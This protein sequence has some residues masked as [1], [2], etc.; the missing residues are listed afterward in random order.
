M[1]NPITLQF[2]STL[3]APRERVWSWITSIDGILAEMRP[4]FRMTAPARVRGLTEVDV[5]P[6]TRL[7]R[8][9]VLLFGFLP[10]DFSDLTLLELRS[11]EGFVEQSPMGSMKLWKH[12]RWI[13]DGP[14]GSTSVKLVDRL[15]FEP[16]LARPVLKWLIRRFF[17]HRH[18]VLRANLGAV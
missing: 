12:E 17:E 15:T 14:A 3:A 11:G 10:V 4:Y 8:S 18:A 9:Y 13:A 7:F 5:V 16:R 6:G 1:S 2:E